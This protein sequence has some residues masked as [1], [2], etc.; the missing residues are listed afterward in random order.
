MGILT[1][2][3]FHSAFP[4]FGAAPDNIWLPNATFWD[5]R[6]EDADVALFFING[7]H[8]EYEYPTNDPVYMTDNKSFTEPTNGVNS[9]LWTPAYYTTVLACIDQ[10]QVCNSKQASRS[11][12]PMVAS[13]RLSDE[14]F[15]VALSDTQLETAKRI[16]R[17]YPTLGTYYTVAGRGASALQATIG[18]VGTTQTRRLPDDQWR[19]EVKQWFAVTLA[20]LQQRVVEYAA[21][22]AIPEVLQALRPPQNTIAAAQ[23]DAQRISLPAGAANFRWLGIEILITIGLTLWVL[24]TVAEQLADWLLKALGLQQR[25]LDWIASGPEGLQRQAYR[26]A[27]YSDGTWAR[28][29]RGTPVWL[30]GSTGEPTSA[31]VN[32][33]IEVNVV[34]ILQPRGQNTAPP[35]GGAVATGNAVTPTPSPASITSSTNTSPSGVIANGNAIPT[36]ASTTSSTPTPTARPVLLPT[37]VASPPSLS[38]SSTTSS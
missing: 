2:I 15:R 29:D 16:V 5:P 35:S 37:A 24:G 19:A 1:R 30:P 26:A 4:Y 20:K 32:G 22:P 33:A 21:A 9:S 25:R 7:D 36:A 6:R 8:V 3:W 10:Y 12:S 28:E 27:G 13:Y 23:C 31:V 17:L 11:C 14:I 18:L 34:R 38:R